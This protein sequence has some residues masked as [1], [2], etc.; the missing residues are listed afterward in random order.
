MIG[1]ELV[2][3]IACRQTGGPADSSASAISLRLFSTP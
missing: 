2:L 1:V 3:G